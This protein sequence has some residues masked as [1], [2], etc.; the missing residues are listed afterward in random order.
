MI[1]NM[2]NK[3]IKG[4]NYLEKKPIKKPG[5]N[6]EKKPNGMVILE[7]ENKG[8]ANRIAQKILKKPKISYIHLDDIGSFVWP[9]IDGERDII[10]IG[11]LVRK[12]FGSGAEPLYERLAEYIKI[13]E[14]HG[15][16]IFE[17]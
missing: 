14:N 11:E 10:E 13:F 15:F 2:K 4:E 9:L 16:V 3:K 12:Q 7:I 1:K 6:W 5:L 17:N 8:I